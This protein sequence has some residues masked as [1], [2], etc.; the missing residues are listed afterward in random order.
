MITGEALLATPA[1]SWWVIGRDSYDLMGSVIAY[2][3]DV[4]LSSVLVSAYA[5]PARLCY[6]NWQAVL[7][8]G[9]INLLICIFVQYRKHSI[10]VAIELHPVRNNCVINCVLVINEVLGR[11]L[12]VLTLQLHVS[13]DA[14]ATVKLLTARGGTR[15]ATHFWT[16]QFSAPF[17]RP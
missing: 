8:S 5:S 3:V 9:R 2:H 16:C 1:F 7:K 6:L 11:M 4:P 15:V 17:A 13:K 12:R 14:F 10:L